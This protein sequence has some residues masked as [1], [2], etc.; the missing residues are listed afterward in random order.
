MTTKNIRQVSVE[1][2]MALSALVLVVVALGMAIGALVG[3][4]SAHSDIEEI[5]GQL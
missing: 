3:N 1:F 5:R 4:G 2:W